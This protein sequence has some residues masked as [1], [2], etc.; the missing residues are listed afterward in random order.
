MI[1]I[2]IAKDSSLPLHMQLLDELRHKIRSGLIKA[3]ER[4]PGEWEIVSALDISR[5]TIQRAWQ[6]AE[7]EG[8]IYRIPGKGT[9]VAEPRPESVVRTAVGLVTPDFRGTFAGQM[10]SGAERVL[11]QQ[12]YYVQLACS[13][14]SIAE[15]NR[16]LWQMREDG[17]CG[18]IVW[19]MKSDGE[20]RLLA[21][22]AQSMP[23]VL[24]DRPVD[25][26]KLPCVTSNNYSGGLQAMQHLIDLGHR[27]IAFLARPHLNLWTVAERYRAYQDA[28]R[29]AGLEPQPPILVG[30]EN[31]LSSYNAYLVGDEQQLEPLLSRLHQPDRP[32]AIFAV[33]DWMAMRA[34]R[35]AQIASLRVPNDLSLVGFDNLDVTD[36]LS[37]PLTSIAQ[38]SE[39]MGSE[40]ARR[41]MALIEGEI[42]QDVLTLLPTTLVKR[43]ST[44]VPPST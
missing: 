33:N 5:A 8:L 10:L 23:V 20:Q 42:P 9:F 22:L 35:A 21:S 34:L 40:A 41:L 19:G 14:Y 43:K 13:E 6:A 24:I 32:T 38:N 26:L 15:E 1:T 27:R 16:V 30:D 12:G 44:A 2:N 17:V 29:A 4:L 7:D 11:R 28:L 37:P 3:H 25:D 39:L 36:Y 31:E 18:W